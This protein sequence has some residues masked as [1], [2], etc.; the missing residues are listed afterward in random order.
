MIKLAS[1]SLVVKVVAAAVMGWQIAEPSN[2]KPENQDGWVFLER[3][4][5]RRK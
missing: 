2:L 5:E 1:T 4:N 3:A